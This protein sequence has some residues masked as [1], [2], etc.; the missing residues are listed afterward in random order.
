MAS[1]C[2]P[3][4]ADYELRRAEKDPLFQVAATLRRRIAKRDWLLANQG[5][6]AAT[7]SEG[8]FATDN[9]FHRD[10]PPDARF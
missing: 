10:Y 3:S 7:R 6:L 4:V 2:A 8:L 1:D 9:D 5:R